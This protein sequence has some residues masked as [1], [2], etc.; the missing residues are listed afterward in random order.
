MTTSVVHRK[1]LQSADRTTWLRYVIAVLAVFVYAAPLYIAVINAF[2]TNEQISLSPIALPSPFTLD[3]ISDV[4]TNP[5]SD[6]IG[7]LL[8]TI[9]V[10]AS[11]VAL[12]VLVGSMLGYYIGRNDRTFQRVLL[13]VLLLG[14]SIPSQVLLI[15]VS[16]ILKSVGLLNSYPGLILY[17]VAFYV[18]F[19]VLI[20]SR[21]VKSIPHELDEAAAIDGAGPLRTYFTVI[22][23]LM[24]PAAASV[25]IFVSIWIWN[26]FVNPLILLGP[27]TGTTV[28]AGLYRTLGQYTSDFGGVFAYMFVA[29]LPVIVLFLFLQRAFVSGLIAGASKG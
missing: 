13:I 27:A 14:L 25:T 24:R 26:D 22:F 1:R 28:M 12:I 4:L 9:A 5:D 10:T 11:S 17:N 29:T 20:F 16:Q 7:T 18:P 21:F 23:P 3:N 6:M 19:A 2:K 15:P 8:R